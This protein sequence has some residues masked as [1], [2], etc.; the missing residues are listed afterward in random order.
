MKDNVVH[1]TAFH[2]SRKGQVTKETNICLE[3]HD[4]SRHYTMTPD[5]N[6]K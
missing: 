1:Y 4:D 5:D 3:Q 2:D 6:L